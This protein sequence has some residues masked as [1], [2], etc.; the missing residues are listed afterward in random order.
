MKGS[1]TPLPF[2]LAT[3]MPCTF[4]VTIAIHAGSGTKELITL[5]PSPQAGMASGLPV[6]IVWTARKAGIPIAAPELSR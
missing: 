1:F 2:L 6:G 5:P 4:P 3:G